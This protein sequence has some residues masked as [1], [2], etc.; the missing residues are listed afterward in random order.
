MAITVSGISSGIDVDSL[1]TQLMEVEQAPLT[2]L[3]TK[4]SKA[5][6]KISALGSL[7]S[8]LAS[9]Q[10][11]AKALVPATGKTAT[12]KFSAYSASIADTSIASITANSSAVAGTYSLE[13]TQLAQAHQIASSA[14]AF[15]TVGTTTTLPTGGTLT[16]SLG[17]AADADATKTTSIAIADGATPEQIRDAIN[18]ASAGV[19]ATVINGSDGKQLVLTGNTSGDDQVITLSGIDGLSYDGSGSGS[20]VDE[21]S[22]MQAAQGSAFK[23]NGIAV[24]A[25]T[26]TVSTAIDGLTL[27]LAK[28]SATGV[29]TSITVT[30]STSSLTTAV[31]AFVTAFNGF[32]TTASSLG[33]YNATTETAGTLNGDSTLRSAQN[34]MRSLLSNIPSEASGSTYKLLSNIGVSMQK[35]GTLAVDATKLSKAISDDFAGVAN[36]VSAVGSAYS[37]AIEGLIGTEGTI[38]ARTS[39]LNTT[40][41]SYEKQYDVISARLEKIEARYRAQFTALDTLIAGLNSTS[42]Y[43]TQQLANLP[44]YNSSN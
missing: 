39:G 34:K 23:L 7:K 42:T 14:S 20:D 25:S 41:K 3:T 28:Q 18:K 24:T 22:Q 8:V 31:N 30:R 6:T 2:K 11:A 1:V 26:N 35:D 33:S 9:L 38:A 29:A 4:Q 15:T 13:V 10:T 16:I 19:S 40:I 44:S 12:D 32:S 36:L 43:L 21:F 5:Q 17:T 27:S 37:G